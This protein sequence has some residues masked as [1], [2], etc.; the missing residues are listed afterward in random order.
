MNGKNIKSSN[1]E[2]SK[3]YKLL[4]KNLFM[5]TWMGDYE[6][7]CKVGKTYEKGLKDLKIRWKLLVNAWTKVILW[8]KKKKTLEGS[9][10]LQLYMHLG[11]KF[12]KNMK[13]KRLMR[14][15]NKIKN[16]KI[17]KLMRIYIGCIKK[18]IKSGHVA[19]K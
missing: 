13:I 9:W 5:Y 17:K 2:E 18:S 4:L 3:I 12:K 16:M 7:K 11:I 8:K 1:K 15:Y 14:N 10:S 6:N 19:D